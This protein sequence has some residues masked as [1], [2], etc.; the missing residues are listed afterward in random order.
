MQGFNLRV[1]FHRFGVA[2]GVFVTIVCGSGSLF[3]ALPLAYSALMATLAGLM[4]ACLF[5]GLQLIPAINR[6]RDERDARTFHRLHRLDVV[7]V[8]AGLL[9]G[10]LLVAGLVY[11]LP[12]V[13][14]HG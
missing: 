6:A 3:S 4:T 7:L 14:V 13:Y 9:F 5:V 12:G 1:R 2:G 11:A 10:T 8:G